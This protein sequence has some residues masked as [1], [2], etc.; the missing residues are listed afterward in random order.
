MKLTYRKEGYRLR[1]EVCSPYSL[2]GFFEL[3]LTA[4]RYSYEV[5]DNLGTVIIPYLIRRKD[6]SDVAM[7][8]EGFYNF[9]IGRTDYSI[10]L[11]GTSESVNN[12][13]IIENPWNNKN[14]I[15]MIYQNDKLA[16]LQN[17]SI[18]PHL[19]RIKN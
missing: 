19:I 17:I 8:A 10:G 11:V 15:E 18:R 7:G 16:Q 4:S 2:G 3:L 5:Y 13:K 12:E 14:Y 9:H 6:S 1:N